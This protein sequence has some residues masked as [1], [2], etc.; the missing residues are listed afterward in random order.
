MLTLT[1]EEHV[2]QMAQAHGLDPPDVGQGYGARNHSWGKD[3]GTTS[4][5]AEA[6]GCCF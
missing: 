3:P 2:W 6:Q 5:S 1:R 4:P